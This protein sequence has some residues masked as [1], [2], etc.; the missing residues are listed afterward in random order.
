MADDRTF[1]KYICRKELIDDVSFWKK[2]DEA[3]KE[4]IEDEVFV[5]LVATMLA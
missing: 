1:N 3:V 5:R 2:Y 4:D